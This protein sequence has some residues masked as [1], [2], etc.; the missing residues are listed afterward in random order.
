MDDDGDDNSHSGG[1]RPWRCHPLPPCHP[2]VDLTFP[3]AAV[4]AVERAV[5]QQISRRGGGERGGDCRPA[6]AAGTDDSIWPRTRELAG[7]DARYSSTSPNIGFSVST[8]LLGGGLLVGEF[9][10]LLSCIKHF[11]IFSPSIFIVILVSTPFDSIP[12]KSVCREPSDGSHPKQSLH[13]IG[14]I[15]VLIVTLIWGPFGR[16][17][18][19]DLS[20]GVPRD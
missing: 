6:T 5:S 8:V 7:N 4:I 15:I 14:S 1:G 11:Y 2:S 16:P 20:S 18:T 10:K 9:F 3:A 13:S 19:R 12:L 17:P